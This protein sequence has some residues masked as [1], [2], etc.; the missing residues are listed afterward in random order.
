[1]SLSFGLKEK[2]CKSVLLVRSFPPALDVM[3]YYGLSENIRKQF[4]SLK[5]TI[6]TA[7]A[8][9]WFRM[10]PLPFQ[11]GQ[12]IDRGTWR[13]ICSKPRWV[14]ALLRVLLPL[15]RDVGL[16]MALLYVICMCLW[17]GR[18]AMRHWVVPCFHWNRKFNP[19]KT[20]RGHAGCPTTF[21]WRT[22][23]PHKIVFEEQTFEKQ[24]V[25]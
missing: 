24:N 13:S 17:Q 1:M 5:Q 8:N 15:C 9:Q 10:V 20:G 11:H 16:Y 22:G 12:R 6:A 23:W 2:Y 21:K 3:A 14:A 4:D 25:R 19:I 7:I 18:R